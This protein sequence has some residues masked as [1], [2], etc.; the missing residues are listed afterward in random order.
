MSTPRVFA[1]YESKWQKDWE[2]KSI[3]QALQPGVSKAGEKFYGLIEFPFPSGAGLHVGHPRSYVAIDVL[4]RKKRMEGKNVLFPIGWDAF[5]LPTENY[6][7]KN[8]VKPQDATIANVNNFRRQL[9]SLGFGFDWN[10]EVNTTDPKYYKWTQ[11]MFLQFFKSEFDESAGRAKYVEDREAPVG[12]TAGEKAVSRQPS[13]VSQSRMAYKTTTTIN[14]CP[15]CKIGLANEE[16]I[17]GVCERCGTA[18]EKREKAQWMI[19]ITKYAERLIQDL[20][21][22]DFLEKI[23]KQQIDWIGRSEGAFIDFNL[24]SGQQPTANGGNTI[25]VFTTRPD[26]LFGVTYVVLA[27]EHEFVSKWMADGSIKNVDD[28]RVYQQETSKKADTDRTAEGKEK[29]GVKL[30]GVTVTNPVNGE[31]V[32]VFIADYVLAGYGTGAVM[33]VPAHDERDFAFAKKYGLQIKYVVTPQ[34]IDTDNPPK[35]GK[36]TVA[37]NTVHAIIRNPKTNQVLCL[38]WK[39]FPWTTFV[40]GGVEEGEALIEAAKRE[41][42]EETGYKN[43]EAKRILGGPIESRYFAAHKDENRIAYATAILFDLQNEEK[44]GP[45]AEELAKHEPEWIDWDQ[46][47]R[48]VVTCSEKSYWLARIANESADCYTEE[49]V[50]INSGLLDGLSTSEAK[51][52]ISSWL[53]EQ[54]KGGPTVNYKLRDWI[55]S[56]Q[57]YWGEPIPIIICPSCGYVPVPED[58]LPILLPD[59]ESYEPSENGESPLAKIRDWVE[60]TCPHCGGKAERETDTMPNWAGSSW[61]FM[62]YCDPHNDEAFSSEEALKYWMPV[63]LYNGG[64]EHTTLHLLYSRFWHKLMWDLGLIP[65]S[66]GSEPYHRRVSHGLILAQG[67]EKMSKSKGNVVNPDEV[68][69]E[70][71]ADVFRAYM[72]FIGPFDQPAPWDTNGIEGVKRFLDKVWRLFEEG[73]GHGAQGIANSNATTQQS[74]N[75]TLETIYHQSIKKISEGIEALG[76]NTAVSQL[77]ILTNAFTEAGGVPEEMKEG[78]LKILAPFA[79]HMTEELW[80]RLGRE[81]SVHVSAW[82][83]YDESKTISSSF[84]LVIQ[85]NGKVR[86]RI[87]VPAD[88]SE[89]EAKTKAL[90]SEHVQKYLE[91]KEPKKIMYVKGKLVTIAV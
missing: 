27:P 10:R 43:I 56:R 40:L 24:A 69:N 2:E 41:V 42:L 9:K 20:G 87:Q 34:V 46:I 61:Y 16:A 64:M 3:Y 81:G 45:D 17:G 79:P 47:D 13:A 89:D 4:T 8:H 25:R 6:A 84:E 80:H 38:R 63:N 22:V 91:G 58:Q 57:R 59:V 18:V 62:R 65:E 30:E 73:I 15:S 68:V 33:A 32:P 72:M 12:P 5:G 48:E 75:A 74:N 28:V 51:K 23:K 29:T 66:V 39:Q 54:G 44:N 60:T 7:I 70:Y 31:E 71:G 85:V 83:T 37:R 77:M 21:Q 19:R 86:D 50:N 82:P 53:A 11:W 14:W 36:K 55:F 76:F 1:D 88:I 90:T 67:G 52:K 78:Y 35:E 49:G 26:T